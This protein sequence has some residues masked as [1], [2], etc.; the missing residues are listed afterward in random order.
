VSKTKSNNPYK[1]VVLVIVV[2]L[3]AVL[4]A[5]GVYLWQRD[6]AKDTERRLSDKGRQ[7][8][9][10]TKQEAYFAGCIKEVL[11]DYPNYDSFTQNQSEYNIRKDICESGSRQYGY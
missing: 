9:E 10:D 1:T 11:D 8:W 4:P 2:A 3:V 7:Q 6:V 5:L